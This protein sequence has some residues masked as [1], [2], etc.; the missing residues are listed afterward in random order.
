[1]VKKSLA[2]YGSY[3]DHLLLWLG[4]AFGVSSTI[5]LAVHHFVYAGIYLSL[6]S[7]RL[8]AL[9]VLLPVIGS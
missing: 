2:M 5:V 9:Y 8:C 4:T 3:Q 7:I 6:K 1:M